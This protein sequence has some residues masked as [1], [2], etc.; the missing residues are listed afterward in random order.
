MPAFVTVASAE[1]IPPGDAKL[2]RLG[3]REIA[4]FNVGGRYYAIDNV[5]HHR[6]APLVDGDL[7][8]TVVSCPWHGWRF[9]VTTG[10]NLFNPDTGVA[11]FPV[12]VEGGEVQIGVESQRRPDS[13]A[14][15]PG[16]RR[17]PEL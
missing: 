1:E 10:R 9:D 3:R 15:V 11:C 17:K 2:V 6:G 8:G 12:R 5:C 16:P 7:E 13:H 4:L 14:T